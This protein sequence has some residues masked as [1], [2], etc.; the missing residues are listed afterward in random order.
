[1]APLRP[2]FPQRKP[3]VFKLKRLS[4]AEIADIAATVVLRVSGQKQ[5]AVAAAGAERQP[6]FTGAPMVAPKSEQETKPP[7][8]TGAAKARNEPQ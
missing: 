3:V 1:M 6:A 2:P 7:F 8:A 5:K 4:V